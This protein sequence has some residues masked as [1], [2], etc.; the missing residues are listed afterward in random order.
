M[1]FGKKISLVSL[2]F[3]VA[4]FAQFNEKIFLKDFK[5]QEFKDDGTP[6]W[7]MSGKNANVS[8]NKVMFES[9]E[10]TL[11]TGQGEV[12][13][14]AGKSIF[15]QKTKNWTSEE[16]VEISGEGLDVTGVGF[17]MN[18]ELKQ[19]HLNN[20]VKATFASIKQMRSKTNENE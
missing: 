6:S 9:S 13:V 12:K 4:L 1:T 2:L 14:S 18:A 3:S 20:K 17:L 15:N 16:K 11:F 10:T 7:R 19:I 8:G 5:T